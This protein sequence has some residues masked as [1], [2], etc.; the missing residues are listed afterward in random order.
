MKP[1]AKYLFAVLIMTEAVI[2]AYRTPGFQTYKA[3]AIGRFGIFLEKAAL[4]YRVARLSSQP[5]D[6]RLL[7]PIQGLRLKNIADSWG[8]PRSGNR[9]HEGIDVFAKK[10][11]PVFSATSGYVVRTGTSTLGGNFVFVVGAGGVRYYYAHLDSVAEGVIFGKEVSTSTVIGFVGNTGNAQDTPPHLHFGM[12]KNGAE[13][14]YE[15]FLSR[16][17]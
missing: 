12:Y 1:A 14:P 3:E 16:A 11:T 17:P 7:I 4:P 8:T 9:L 2:L 13:N 6:T 10:G 15:L 5:R